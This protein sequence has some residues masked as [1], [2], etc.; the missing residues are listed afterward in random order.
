MADGFGAFGKMPSVG[1]FF[2]LNMPPGFVSVW[3]DWLQHALLSGQENSGE[4]WVEHY[5]SAPIWRFSLPSGIAGDRGILGIL[6]P[7]VDRVGRR[8]P[9]TFAAGIAQDDPARVHFDQTELF[10]NLEDLA[11][12]ALDDSMTRD[13]LE[14]R[15]TGIDL[16]DSGC[17]A[18]EKRGASLVLKGVQSCRVSSILAA[19]F[20]SDALPN[21][22]VW[23]SV[24]QGVERGI[25]SDG[26]PEGNDMQ[27][28]FNLHAPVWNETTNS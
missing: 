21:A 28:L 8:F 1:D 12:D 6:M 22:T 16:P 13:D 2:R 9:L 25:V 14:E 18:I 15:L 10:E 19:A 27:G 23:T 24:V 17:A 3:D 26:L 7:S 4:D 11:L 20:V 5:M